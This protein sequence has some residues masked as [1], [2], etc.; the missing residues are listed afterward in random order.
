MPYNEI[1]NS[2]ITI[3]GFISKIMTETLI[4]NKTVFNNLT[5]GYYSGY[6]IDDIYDENDLEE[7]EDDNTQ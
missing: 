5:E 1:I 7:E 3:N 2:G 6:N 4:N